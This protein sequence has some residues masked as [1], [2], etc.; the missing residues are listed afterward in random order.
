MKNRVTLFNMLSGLLLQFCTIMSG[1]IVPRIILAYFGS[2]TNG[3]VA[4]LNQFLSYIALVEGGLTGVITASLYKPLVD[5]DISKVSS[6]LVT[7]KQFYK[8]ISLIFIIY[9]FSL[10]AIYPLII[11]SRFDCLHIVALT[12]VLSIGM[13]IQY[14]F[15][16]TLK[17]LLDADKKS[18]VVSLTQCVIIVLNILVALIVVNVYPQIHVLKLFTGLLFIIQP[19]LYGRFVKM[20]Y[21]IDWG[22]KPD[23]SLIKNRWNGFAIN[24]AAFIHNSTDIVILT[25]FTDLKTVSIYSVYALVTNGLKQL[26]NSTT[27]GINPTIGQSYARNDCVQLNQK[28]D[29]YEY[30]IFVLVC[31]CYCLSTLL[32]TPFVLLYTSGVTDTNYNQP[33]F[34]I[35]LSLSE[36]LYL[37]KAPHLGLAYSA[38]KFKEISIPAYI[39]AGLNILVSAILVYKL[40]LIGVA[41]GTIVGM[42]YRLIFHVYYTSKIV[43]N[44]SQMIFYKKFTIFTCIFVIGCLLSHLLYPIHV[45]SIVEWIIH[46]IV[47]SLIIIS[48]IIFSSLI[49]FKQELKFVKHYLIKKS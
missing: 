49:F 40:G 8:K 24:I 33:I 9:T 26:I 41:I 48:L 11:N 5:H 10:A 3:L 27:S 37:I 23:N 39:E 42:T 4:S 34:G 43:Q 20:H 19:L 21:E 32:I 22:A 7:A 6:I 28:M 1:F 17:T 44:R 47:Y 15:S 36:V 13:I 38:N 14:M 18:Y 35:L 31:F 25:L 16:L 12:I 29:L 2:D 46:A 45:I 30:V